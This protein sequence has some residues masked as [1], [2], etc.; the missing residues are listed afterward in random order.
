MNSG[1]ETQ[2]NGYYNFL[3]IDNANL[4]K[5]R[6]L[7]IE[8]AWNVNEYQNG[9]YPSNERLQSAKDRIKEAYLDSESQ[10]KKLGDMKFPWPTSGKSEMI[11]AT[12]YTKRLAD[13]YAKDFKQINEGYIKSNWEN[14]EKVFKKTKDYKTYIVL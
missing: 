13:M 9:K 2:H 7:L 4:T 11:T 1:I 10:I 8:H 6:N 12:E 5:Y 3:N 14:I